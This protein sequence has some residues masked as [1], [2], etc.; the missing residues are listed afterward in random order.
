MG[1]WSIWTND[2][3]LVCKEAGLD[4]GKRVQAL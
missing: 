4:Y 3:G 2:F 1:E